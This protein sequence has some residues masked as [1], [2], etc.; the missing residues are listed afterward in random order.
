MTHATNVPHRVVIVGGGFGGLYAARVLGSDRRVEV[1][2]FVVIVRWASSFVT[3]R[4]GSRL[5]TGDRSSR[6]SR[7]PSAPA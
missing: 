2:R 3:H 4:R 5:I 1:T 7:N 6:Q